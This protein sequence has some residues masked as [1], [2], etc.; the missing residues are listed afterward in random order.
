MN[1]AKFCRTD[2][3]KLLD[4]AVAH[5]LKA[6]GF[7]EEPPERRWT[8][9]TGWQGY[10]KNEYPLQ[11]HNWIS[12]IPAMAPVFLLQSKAARTER[13]TKVGR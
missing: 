11:N 6:Q 7:T 4:I 13:S 10:P 8:W 5:Y 9:G 12:S 1:S 2:S 3:S